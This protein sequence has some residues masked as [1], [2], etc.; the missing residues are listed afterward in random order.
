MLRGVWNPGQPTRSVYHWD[1]LLALCRMPE[2]F[3]LAQEFYWYNP[4]RLPGPAEWVTVRRVRVKDAVDCVWWLP[5][6]PHPRA[7]NRNVLR[8]AAIPRRTWSLWI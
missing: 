6:T 5:K 4:A 1:L 7:D 2:P 8:R 3:Y